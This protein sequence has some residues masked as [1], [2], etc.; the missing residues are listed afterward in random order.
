MIIDINW[1]Q[2]PFILSCT[3][4]I[5]S[6]NSPVHEEDLININLETQKNEHISKVIMILAK[7][8]VLQHFYTNW[9]IGTIITNFKALRHSWALSKYAGLM[10]SDQLSN[11][12]ACLTGACFSLVDCFKLM[13]RGRGQFKS[14]QKHIFHQMWYWDSWWLNGV[15]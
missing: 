12:L 2:V 6:P 13:Q 3:F 7:K 4:I 14:T 9:E 15:A 11:N 8:H 10:S 5:Q 1:I